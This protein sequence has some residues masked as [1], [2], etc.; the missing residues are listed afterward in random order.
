LT[1]TEREIEKQNP[2]CV[3]KYGEL[4]AIVENKNEIRKKEEMI[5]TKMKPKIID[6]S[7]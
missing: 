4:L 6:F 7:L 5:D 1:Q 2:N 3:V